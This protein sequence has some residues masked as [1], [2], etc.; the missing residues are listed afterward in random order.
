MVYRG[1][2]IARDYLNTSNVSFVIKRIKMPVNDIHIQ[3]WKWKFAYCFAIFWNL[4][5]NMTYSI[6]R[7]V[8]MKLSVIAQGNCRKNNS[9]AMVDGIAKPIIFN[10]R[11]KLQGWFRQS[12][13]NRKGK[14]SWKYFDESWIKEAIF[15]SIPWQRFDQS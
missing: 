10:K 6:L 13:K 14:Y 2:L 11:R 5:R 3:N 8:K 12:S 1:S 9:A 15:L 4:V 7:L